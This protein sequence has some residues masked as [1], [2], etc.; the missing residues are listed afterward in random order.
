MS[1]QTSKT[2][3]EGSCK[4][5]G[6][7]PKLGFREAIIGCMVDNDYIE[8]AEQMQVADDWHY[9]VES[10][11]RLWKNKEQLLTDKINAALAEAGWNVIVKVQFAPKDDDS[12]IIDLSE[13]SFPPYYLWLVREGHWDD[14][15]LEVE[16][17]RDEDQFLLR[18]IEIVLHDTDDTEDRVERITDILEGDRYAQDSCCG[19]SYYIVDICPQLL[20]Q[21]GTIKA[22]YGIMGSDELNYITMPDRDE[23][24]DEDE[25]DEA[26]E[27]FEAD[28]HDE[29][30]SEYYLNII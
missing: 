12:F 10:E 17:S 21:P 27:E 9:R 19:D 28:L 13:H 7:D 8:K 20:L 30:L 14:Y 15:N 22:E 18:L 6:L 23:Y 4:V 25:Y 26:R 5:K 1:K 24:E 29:G 3:W 16:V 11:M 2:G